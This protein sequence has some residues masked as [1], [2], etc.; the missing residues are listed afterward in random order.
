MENGEDVSN[1][2][3]GFFYTDHDL[4]A[5]RMTD[6]ERNASRDR[7]SLLNMIEASNRRIAELG[8]RI[9]ELEIYVD[10]MEENNEYV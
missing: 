5:Q 7:V 2:Q 10:N 6:L 1:L 3:K 8:N 4:Y 9:A